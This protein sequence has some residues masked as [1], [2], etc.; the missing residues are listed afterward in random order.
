MYPDLS[1]FFHDLFGSAPDN[2]LSVI[3][4]FGFFLILSF[5]AA[6]YALYLELKRKE[7]EG[8]LRGT[9]EKEKIGFPPTWQE[10]A[11]NAFFGFV[12]GFKV[13]YIAQH[14]D[15]FKPDPAKMIFSGDGMM[16]YGILGA[17]L[18]GGLKYWDKKK[19]QLAKPLIKETLVMPN[20]RIGDITILAAISGI[21]GAR[22]FSIIESEENIKAFMRDPLDQL[23]SGS[24]LAIYGG[25]IVAFITVYLYVKRKGMKPIHMMDAVAPALILGYAV[26]RLGCQF[27]GDGDWGIVN[28]NPQPGWWFLP[29]WAWTYTYPHNVLN[30]GVKIDGCLYN[31]CHQLSEGVYPTPLYEFFFGII[32]F[33]ILWSLRKRIKIPGVLF[34]IYAFLNGIERFF[35]E[36]IRTNPDINLLGMKATQAEYVAGLLIIIGAVG[37]AYLYIKRPKA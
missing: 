10:V 29:D 16:L 25:L 7:K 30:D 19:K 24:G 18:F 26:G 37:T 20:Q 23:L 3:K 4:T 2:W 31:Y 27:S 17:A 28:T 12:L 36:K 5:L 34:F 21:I 11:L 33:T 14:F 13:P 22:L 1:Y 32:I 15:A 9:V 35:I 6:A 8:L